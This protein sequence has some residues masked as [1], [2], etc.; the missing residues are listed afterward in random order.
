MMPESFEYAKNGGRKFLFHNLGNGKFE[1]VSE[2]VGIK[3]SRWALAA[4]AADLR[5][6]GHPDL[7]IANDYGVSELYLNDGGH[8]HEA[9][10]ATGV[11]FAPKSGMNVALRRHSEPGQVLHLCLQYLPG[12]SFDPGQ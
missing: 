4:S 9:G 2:K 11:G 10:E 5:G 3:S 6:T 8:F 12:G 1:E 7:F